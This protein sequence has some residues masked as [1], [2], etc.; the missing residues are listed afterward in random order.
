MEKQKILLNKCFEQG[1]KGNGK[2]IEGKK[3]FVC[4][5]SS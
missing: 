5:A 2:Y 3:L 4:V 1:K